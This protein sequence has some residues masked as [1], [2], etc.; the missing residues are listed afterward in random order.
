M[1]RDRVQVYSYHGEEVSSHL[2]VGCDEFVRVWHD[3]DAVAK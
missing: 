3:S 1:L 2:G